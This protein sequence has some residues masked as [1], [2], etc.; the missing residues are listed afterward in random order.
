MP[1]ADAKGTRSAALGAWS[2]V[3]H[4]G[5]AVCTFTTADGSF[6]S[7]AGMVRIRQR[8]V[9]KACEFQ[10]P[11]GCRTAAGRRGRTE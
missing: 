6:A 10:K 2:R 5:I 4:P 9:V 1:D 7:L 11:T 3:R 8:T